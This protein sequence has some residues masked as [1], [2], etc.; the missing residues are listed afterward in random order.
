MDTSDKENIPD[1][2]SENTNITQVNTRDYRTQQQQNTDSDGSDKSLAHRIKQCRANDPET[3]MQSTTQTSG[4]ET[5]L[6]PIQPPRLHPTPEQKGATALGARP[7]EAPTFNIGEHHWETLQ[8]QSTDP[9]AQLDYQQ[10]SFRDSHEHLSTDTDETNSTEL[11]HMHLKTGALIRTMRTIADETTPNDASSMSQS[12]CIRLATAMDDTLT[13]MHDE[14]QMLEETLATAQ[15]PKGH[16]KQIIIE[17]KYMLNGLMEQIHKL[18]RHAPRRFI[19]QERTAPTLPGARKFVELFLCNA[20]RNDPAP[21]Q[22]RHR[23][24]EHCDPYSRDEENGGRNNTDR[25]HTWRPRSN[26]SGTPEYM[27]RKYG[28][29]ERRLP[30]YRT[31]ANNG[32][33]NNRGQYK[34]RDTAHPRDDNTAKGHYRNYSPDHRH[35]Q[36]Y[37]TGRNQGPTGR[38]QTQQPYR[39]RSESYDPTSHRQH[40]NTQNRPANR[41]NGRYFFDPAYKSKMYDSTDEEPSSDE[42]DM[43]DSDV[44]EETQHHLDRM[45]QPKWFS[46]E[47]KPD[48][49]KKPATRDCPQ[50]IKENLRMAYA[51]MKQENIT[52][53]ETHKHMIRTTKNHLGTNLALLYTRDNPALDSTIQEVKSMITQISI[54]QAKRRKPLNN[55][56]EFRVPPN[57]RYTDFT[58][59]DLYKHNRMNSSKEISDIWDSAYKFAITEELTHST[60]KRVL[61]MV[62]NG[63]AAKI[64]DRSIHN[65]VK[66]IAKKLQTIYGANKLSVARTF[67]KNLKRDKLESISS[68]MARAEPHM[69][70]MAEH[71]PFQERKTRLNELMKT[72]LKNI[73]STKAWNKVETDIEEYSQKNFP[74]TPKVI[75]QKLESYEDKAKYI[76]NDATD[77]KIMVN[78]L[79]L[80]PEP[81]QADN[82][83][84]RIMTECM[85]RINNLA[86]IP[87]AANAGAKSQNTGNH[88]RDATRRQK[89]RDQSDEYMDR[90]RKTPSRERNPEPM[91]TSRFQQPRPDQRTRSRSSQRTTPYDRPPS[92]DYKDRGSTKPQTENTFQSEHRKASQ[93]RENLVRNT[94]P[95]KS[96][97]RNPANDR[98]N[99]PRARQDSNRRDDNRQSRHTDSRS[100]SNS[101]QPRS[102]DDQPSAHDSRPRNHSQEQG[103]N[104][105]RSNDWYPRN[106]DDR[107]QRY[108]SRDDRRDSYDSNR[109][110]ESRSPGRERNRFN[111]NSYDDNRNSRRNNED[112]RS[113]ND[114]TPSRYVDTRPRNNDRSNDNRSRRDQY[115]SRN[116]SYNNNGRQNSRNYRQG[117]QS[118]DR[119]NY[120]DGSNNYRSNYRDGSANYRPNYRDTSQKYRQAKQQLRDQEIKILTQQNQG[121][122][123]QQYQA[124]GAPQ[125][126]VYTTL[127]TR[128]P[129]C[130]N[131]PPAL[132]YQQPQRQQQHTQGNHAYL[133]QPQ[134]QAIQ[135]PTPAHANYPNA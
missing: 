132:T 46:K 113:N 22:P 64:L 23:S 4:Y 13:S 79:H 47:Y 128:P 91:D 105:G 59:D 69:Q 51:A 53:I 102:R 72:T 121:C 107:P 50:A 19:P 108:T 106:Q 54:Y 104:R 11:E 35:D 17:L 73:A 14:E 80:T 26:D 133:Q 90:R 27:L 10:T 122:Q 52:N 45:N 110:R 25:A 65:S 68:C 66:I 42:E 96:G 97:S 71:E 92:R 82:M 9:Q 16:A 114:Y 100:Y 125:N 3:D 60:F 84:D 74:I 134:Q 78:K 76:H 1:D 86:L 12:N 93:E 77:A 129:P 89:T 30:Y 41:T 135:A 111:S 117:F 31:K 20:A 24:R 44:D 15:A 101:W 88:D 57:G 130:P 37:N 116:R 48:Y 98:W 6:N 127:D 94:A 118:R 21:S 126:T 32:G 7:K 70:T 123:H 58:T 28:S 95:E 67:L 62:L 115:D 39:A 43:S 29:P 56:D 87:E 8:N 112:R 2:T 40:R 124:N 109:R 63:D 36:T 81:N 38:L 119:S 55:K 34:P 103:S 83:E 75:M 85:A 18:R 120:R 61:G 131:C 49:M 5:I 99:Q 33:T